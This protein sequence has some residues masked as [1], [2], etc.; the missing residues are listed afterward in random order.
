[1]PERRSPLAHARGNLRSSRVA[2][3]ETSPQRDV[4]KT[5]RQQPLAGAARISRAWLRTAV[6]VLALALLAAAITAVIA[7]GGAAAITAAI[8]APAAE[9]AAVAAVAPFAAVSTKIAAIDKATAAGTE[10]AG[11]KT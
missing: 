3:S 10:A 9:T 7:A 6:A 2:R 1:M 8:T 4:E 11:A 5:Q